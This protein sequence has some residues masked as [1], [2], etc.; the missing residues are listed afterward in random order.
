MKIGITMEIDDTYAD[1]DH[2]TGVTEEGYARITGTLSEL[3]TNIDV[4]QA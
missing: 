4:T 3:G 1:P 2:P